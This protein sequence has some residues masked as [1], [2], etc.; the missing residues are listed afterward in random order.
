METVANVFVKSDTGFEINEISQV[1][2]VLDNNNYSYYLT[3]YS[4][5]FLN[6]SPNIYD[7]LSFDYKITT[8][9]TSTP[10]VETTLTYHKDITAGIYDSDD[11][12][13]LLNSYF[14]TTIG[15][16]DYQPLKFV[17]NPITERTEIHYNATD[18]STLHIK[19]IEIVMNQDSILNNDLFRFNTNTD[20]NFNSTDT[21]YQSTLAFRISTYN[22]VILTS[23]SIPGLVS[24]YGNDDGI[25]TSS[26]LY[27]VSSVASPYSMIEYV[28]LQPVDFPINNVFNLSNFQFKLMD[29]NNN[30]L[31]L[32]PGGTPDFSVKLAIKRKR[33]I[34]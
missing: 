21:Y 15:A 33:R 18:A 31:K 1:P 19:K 7:H 28:A 32:L 5:S 12:I 34:N 27:V 25:S 17:I 23:S 13:D 9:D 16:V 26:A 20:L 22:N 10:P 6:C 8:E 2:L 3:L 24:L 4:F 30:D 29:E 11:I 14:L